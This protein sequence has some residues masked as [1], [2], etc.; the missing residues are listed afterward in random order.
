VKKHRTERSQEPWLKIEMEERLCLNLF[1]TLQ[2]IQQS[3]I[4]EVVDYPVDK[5]MFP[6]FLLRKASSWKKL[7][8]T[9]SHS[10]SRLASAINV[11]L[12]SIPTNSTLYSAAGMLAARQR[13]V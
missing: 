13:V 1:V 10:A 11:E 7:Q 4:P 6:E 12:R 8:G 9:F 2:K 5:K 3:F